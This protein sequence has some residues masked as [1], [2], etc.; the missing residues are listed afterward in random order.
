MFIFLGSTGL[1]GKP[2]R[3]NK[4]GSIATWGPLYR[5]SLDLILYK[6][7]PP[8]VKWMTVLTFKV[9]E[10]INLDRKPSIFYKKGQIF[11]SDTNSQKYHNIEL[12]KWMKIVIEQ[13][14]ESTSGKVRQ[15][16]HFIVDPC[17]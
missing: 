12:N 8:N 3:N 16:F 17:R 15:Q 9:D 2:K 6:D 10:K 13:T 7:P 5:V 4:I 14:K 1:V 11:F